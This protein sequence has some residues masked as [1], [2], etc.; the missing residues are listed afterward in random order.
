[1][2]ISKRYAGVRRF[3]KEH[4]QSV[5]AYEDW[6]ELA[7]D[8]KDVDICKDI[9]KGIAAVVGDESV[10]MKE[11]RRGH[12]LMKKLHLILAEKYFHHYCIYLEWNREPSKR[13]YQPRMRALYPLTDAL[14]KLEDDELDLVCISLPPGVGKSTLALFYLTWVGGKHPEMQI[15]ESSHN[16]AFLRGCYDEVLRIIDPAGEYL[17]NDVFPNSPKVNT[18]AKDLRIDLQMEKRFETFQ[19]SSIGAGNAG[20]VRATSLL[21]CDDLVDGIET[22]VNIVQLDK[23]WNMYATDLRQRKQG[24]RCKELHIATRWSVHDII[25]RLEETHQKDPR[26]KFINVPA[27]NE[28]DESNF[29]YPYGLGFSTKMYHD[30]R[31]TMN[32]MDWNALYMGQP[33]EREGLLFPVES[34]Q[35]YY[36]LPTEEPDAVWAVCDTKDK[37]DDFFCCP[38]LC[39]YNNQ[40]YLADVVYDNGLP[41]SVMPRIARKLVQNGVKQCR[42]ESNSAGGRIATEVEKMVREMGGYTKI[43][44]KYST[45][46]KETK[47]LVNADFVKDYVLFK[48]D[49]RC[50]KEYQDFMRALTGY[51]HM[52]KNRHD[53]APD[54]MTMFAEFVQSSV[55]N[56][57]EI[58][59]R[60]F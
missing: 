22:A 39:Q 46:N 4:P 33:I 45:A 9:L 56:K 16:V 57:V 53:D 13:F 19:F 40:Y 20:K 2:A 28:R 51:T 15:L 23:L 18:N 31:D 6:F 24:D 35:R 54:A 58:R 59:K 29:E 12:E 5:E 1:M 37:G 50:G 52:G 14:Q 21:Y 43:T 17:Y 32:E 11:R 34:L 60:F 38:I 3:I 30:L 10:K 26:A 55:G 44:T 7:R 25:G 27:L 8:A 36:E 47:I 48:D 49:L 41:E 42:F